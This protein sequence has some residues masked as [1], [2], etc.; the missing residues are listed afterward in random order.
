MSATNAAEDEP[1]PAAPLCKQLGCMAPAKALG[2]RCATHE[3]TVVDPKPGYPRGVFSP[4][5]VALRL[6]AAREAAPKP[7]RCDTCGV[8][9]PITTLVRFGDTPSMFVSI[10]GEFDR[11]VCEDRTACARRSIQMVGA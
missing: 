7:I 9:E 3:G 6:A 8:Y 10:G 11:L 2:L 4:E 5:A 1:D